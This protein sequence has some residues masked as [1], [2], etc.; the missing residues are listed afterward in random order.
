MRI[1]YNAKIQTLDP[2]QAV[3][4]AL[5]IE[6]ECLYERKSDR[7]TDAELHLARWRSYSR[8]PQ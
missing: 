6:L 8:A 3:A 5:A 1:L 7:K 2:I 4:S